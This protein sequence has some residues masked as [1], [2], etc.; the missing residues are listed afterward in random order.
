MIKDFL[1]SFKD[2]FKDK[3]RN[4]FL[5][6]YLI[7]WLIRN[8]ELVYSLFNFDNHLKLV[9]KIDFIK[10]FYTKNEFLI[11]LWTNVYWSLG[12]LI[13]TYLLL[14]ISRLITNLSEKRLTPWIYKI[15][16]SN[17][18]VLKTEFNRIRSDRDEL[19]IRLDHERELK[20]K[21]DNRIKILEE[22]IIELTSKKLE[23]RKDEVS[24]V[25][26]VLISTLK[27]NHL[28]IELFEF[29]KDINSGNHIHKNKNGLNTFIELGLLKYNKDSTTAGYGFYEFTS[30]GQ[31]VIRRLRAE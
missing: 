2:N 4:P 28:V 16:D 7:V 6:T 3:T 27:K 8:W 22:K 20:S 30:D 24:D 5:G 15:T 11:N 29:L 9:D 25:Y 31:E 1:V 21:L 26:S 10:E 13:L 17:S 14:N 23:D 19:Q 12:L 18:I